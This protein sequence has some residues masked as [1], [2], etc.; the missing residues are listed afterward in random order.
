MPKVHPCNSNQSEVGNAAFKIEKVWFFFW[1][2]FSRLKYSVKIT[3]KIDL[4]LQWNFQVIV[5]N[6]PAPCKPLVFI[7]TS[8]PASMIQ[9]HPLFQSTHSVYRH[10]FFAV[11]FILKVVNQPIVHE[12]CFSLFSFDVGWEELV[13]ID[14]FETTCWLKGLVRRLL[15]GLL[16][17]FFFGKNR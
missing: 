9:I 6:E 13:K 5:P 3:N 16:G 1:F 15:D 17:E 4:L 10:H 12:G 8:V 2:G 7:A 11:I 14:R